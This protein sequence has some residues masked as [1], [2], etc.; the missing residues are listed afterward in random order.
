MTYAAAIAEVKAAIDAV[1]GISYAA[2]PRIDSLMNAPKGSFD[3]S[4]LLIN[5]SEAEPWPEIS[6]NP[7][8]WKSRMLLEVGTELTTDRLEQDKTAVTRGV[9]IYEALFYSTLTNC[10]LYDPQPPQM[11]REEQSK[12]LVWTVRFT[13]RWTE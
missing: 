9:S 2:D 6:T 5:E 7:S 13:M 11:L 10:A 1:S 4:F 12:R 8:H 3:G